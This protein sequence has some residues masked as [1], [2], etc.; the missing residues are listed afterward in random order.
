[1]YM[2]DLALIAILRRRGWQARLRENDSKAWDNGSPTNDA[3]TFAEATH[4][5]FT[6]LSMSAHPL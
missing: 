4:V 2:Y 6:A 3:G 5:S 1:M